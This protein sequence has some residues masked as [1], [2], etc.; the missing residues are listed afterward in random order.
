MQRNH[1]WRFLR[2][3]VVYFRNETSFSVNSFG[4]VRAIPGVWLCLLKARYKLQL[5]RSASELVQTLRCS[6]AK[7]FAKGERLQGWV[8]TRTQNRPMIRTL[9]SRSGMKLAD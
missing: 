8:Q 1:A 6:C 5:T 9:R 7:P 4:L 2:F 3:T